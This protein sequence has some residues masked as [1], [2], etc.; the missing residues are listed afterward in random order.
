MM[1]M[2]PHLHSDL[3]IR[4]KRSRGEITDSLMDSSRYSSALISCS[5]GDS[6][7]DFSR[8]AKHQR[9]LSDLFPVMRE[10][11]ADLEIEIIDNEQ[12]PFPKYAQFNRPIRPMPK[13]K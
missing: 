10:P 4:E 12:S 5:S 8:S 2:I 7:D 11:L 6:G 3:D 1:M 13:V 9:A